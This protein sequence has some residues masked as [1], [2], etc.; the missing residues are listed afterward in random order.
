MK[1]VSDGEINGH[2]LDFLSKDVDW[3]ATRLQK[4]LSRVRQQSNLPKEWARSQDVIA[5]IA[6]E[7]SAQAKAMTKRGS[8]PG[9]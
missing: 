3:K 5:E 4:K 9:L 6:L 8:H 1:R 2:H 7:T